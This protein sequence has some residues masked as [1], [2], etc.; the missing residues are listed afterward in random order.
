MNFTISERI[1]VIFKLYNYMQYINNQIAI[2]NNEKFV[3]G[4][5]QQCIFYQHKQ[6]LI[7]KINATILNEIDT[8]TDMIKKDNF[9]VK[10]K[11]EVIGHSNKIILKRLSNMI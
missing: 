3:D 1:Y 10:D 7:P 9:N 6:D 2:I 11:E 4:Y 5:S 8:I